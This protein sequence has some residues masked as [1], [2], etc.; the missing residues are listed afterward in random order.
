MGYLRYFLSKTLSDVRTGYDMRGHP[1][2]YPKPDGAEFLRI[3]TEIARGYRENF[4]EKTLREVGR[5]MTH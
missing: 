2:K 1:E 4:D 3:G 5:S